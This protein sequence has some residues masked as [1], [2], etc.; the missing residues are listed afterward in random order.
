MAPA[1]VRQTDDRICKQVRNAAREHR[2]AA[3]AWLAT[4]RVDGSRANRGRADA[5]DAL[6]GMDS[7]GDSFVCQQFLR[8]NRIPHSCHCR[9]PFETKSILAHQTALFGAAAAAV[10]AQEEQRRR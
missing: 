9:R 6:S 7:Q 4:G 1:F 8:C 10:R 3:I 2:A 5:V